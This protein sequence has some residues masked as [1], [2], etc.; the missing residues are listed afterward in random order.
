MNRLQ[1]ASQ[2][3]IVIGTATPFSGKADFFGVLFQNVQSKMANHG[4][5]F[6]R[7]ILSDPTMIL[8]ERHI[9]APM[10]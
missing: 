5:I 6:C 1:D 10:E 2:E 8:V 9:Q 7:V 3:S 4:H